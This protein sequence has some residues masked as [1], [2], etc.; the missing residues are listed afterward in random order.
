M[1]ALA[2]G[3][4]SAPPAISSRGDVGVLDH[5]GDRDL[6]VVGRG[7]RHE[8]GVRRHARVPA[9]RGAGL[10]GDLDAGDRGRRCAVPSS[11]VATISCGDL[12][13]GLG[14]DRLGEA[15]RARSSRA[16]RGRATGPRRRGRASSPCR[17]LAIPAATIAICS[18]VARTSNWP[19]PDWP[20]CGSF[21]VVGEDEL[22]LRAEVVEV[23]VVE[24]ELLGLVAQRVRA[25]LDRRARRR[26][27]CRTAPA[28]G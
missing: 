4:P 5:H 24:A 18:G 20:V 21:G 23:V 17:S 25:E 19:M 15:P 22:G 13:G 3:P 16:R 26:W 9:L 6:R 10:A 7:E 28:P 27:C 12:V 1:T 11:T 2:I 14:G 8:P